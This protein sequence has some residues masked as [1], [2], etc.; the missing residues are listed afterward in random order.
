[1]WRMVV[2]F[3]VAARRFASMQR[4]ARVAQD[5]NARLGIRFKAGG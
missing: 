2:T 1:M 4:R 3:L 5:S